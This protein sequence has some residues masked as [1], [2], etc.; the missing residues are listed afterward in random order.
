VVQLPEIRHPVRLAAA[1]VGVV[2]VVAVF[3]GTCTAPDQRTLP[4]PDPTA[5]T[6]PEET[7]TTIDRSRVFLQPV[8]GQTTTTLAESG[9]AVL[10]GTVTGPNGPVPGAIVRIERL[11]GDAVQVREARTGDDGTWI[12][13]GLPG[14]RMRV[15]AY[16]PPSLTMLEPEV[17][18]LV[19]AEPREL[20]LVVREHAGTF[21]LTDVTP[22]SPTVGSDV[23]VAVRVLERVVDDEG[24]A[25]TR[26]LA[27]QP[28]QVRSSGW[29]FV[30]GPGTTGSDGVAVFTFRCEQPSTVTAAVVLSDGVE[31]RTFPL[32]VPSCA[33]R[34]TTTTTT[35][36]TTTPDPD[37]TT[38]T[39]APTTTEDG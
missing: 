30:D 25:R 38:S 3:G 7:T 32:D 37:E 27:G 39:S 14:G 29:V 33:P 28:L 18:F 6:Q 15:R 5:T 36:S 22:S 10:R 12:H 23:N 13:E 20:Q 26:P 34:P 1:V 8:A 2:L 31:E 17:F 16:A 21:V 9:D 4:P 35:T 24:V 19:E 11:V